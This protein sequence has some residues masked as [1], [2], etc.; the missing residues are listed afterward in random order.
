MTLEFF[1]PSSRP[2]FYVTHPLTPK[3]TL[4]ACL[5]ES[6]RHDEESELNELDVLDHCCRWDTTTFEVSV[7]IIV[8]VDKAENLCVFLM[9]NTFPL[10]SGKIIKSY[11]R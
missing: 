11:Q 2:S 10:F 3:A 9:L 6:E 1:G 4:S 5:H 8:A 7:R